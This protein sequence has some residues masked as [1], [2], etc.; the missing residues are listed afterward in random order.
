LKSINEKCHPD[1]KQSVL[2]FQERCKGLRIGFVE[3]VIRHFF[4]GSKANRKYH[5]RWKILVKYQYS[6]FKMVWF[7][8]NFLLYPRHSFPQ[9]MKDEIRA[10]FFERNDDEGLEEEDEIDIPVFF[11][12]K[13]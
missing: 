13:C 7:D 2:E 6:P 4:H 1:Y 11:Q 9:G 8:N 5:D 12:A 3:G 10:Y